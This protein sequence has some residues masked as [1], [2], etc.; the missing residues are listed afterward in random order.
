MCHRQSMACTAAVAASAL[1]PHMTWRAM[2]VAWH[3]MQGML[4]QVG[5]PGGAGGGPAPGP[6]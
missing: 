4:Q 5:L 6:A 2:R 3:A 1:P